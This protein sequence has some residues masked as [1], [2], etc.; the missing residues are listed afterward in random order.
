MVLEYGV[1]ENQEMVGNKKSKLVQVSVV[2][3]NRIKK[4]RP[5][6]KIVLR[7]TFQHIKAAA[8]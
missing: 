1:I 5:L 2:V 7:H 6:L 3:C 4:S 8:I